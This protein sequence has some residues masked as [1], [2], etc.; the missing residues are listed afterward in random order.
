MRFRI[1]KA[2]CESLLVLCAA[3]ALLAAPQKKQDIDIY[4]QNPR[5]WQYEG[6]PVLLLGG[7]VEDNLFQMPDVED[8]LDTLAR[9]GGNYVRCTMS[10]R[11]EGNVWPFEKV[12]GQYNLEKWNPEFWRR[13][14]NFLKETS[15]RD[16]IAQIEIWATFD[17]YRD[18]WAANPFNPK[19]NVNY[20][21]QETGLPIK[22][23][24]HP[25]R[26]DNDFFRSIPAVNNQ[27]KVLKYQRRFVDKI[28]EHSLRYGNVLYCMDNET[29]VTPEWAKYWAQHIRKKAK[30]AGKT[31]HV[32]EMWDPWDLHHKKHKAT[33]EH[34]ELYTF[35]D[36]SQN[37]HNSGQ[38]H[39]DNALYARKVTR[40]PPRP[41]N[42]IKIYGADTGRYGKTKDGVERF[43]RHI[44]AG[45]ASARFHRP[46]S[47]IGLNKLARR[48]IGSAREVTGAFDIFGCSPRP[49]LLSSRDENEAYCLAKP[50]EQYAVYF[51]SKGDVKVDLSDAKG[52]MRVKWFD[53]EKG[54][55]A[56]QTDCHGGGALRLRT[57]GNRLWA[58]V[59]R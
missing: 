55:W 6:R 51:P 38:K 33:F 24:T 2:V 4:K 10:C 20:T 25:V 26:T 53:I 3:G 12:G 16:V 52:S 31:V 13:F 34:P 27:K 45:L 41:I 5:Y 39:Y 14:E 23:P 49:D 21:A 18:L 59:I 1:G 35:V 36:I 44:F 19:N 22:V 7:S 56:S 54:E 57:P 28:L 40:K 42:S 32:T 37:N 46:D 11:D 15:K 29:A 9:A 50:G 8:H 30:Q 47:G 58:A 48:M 17:Y 43:W